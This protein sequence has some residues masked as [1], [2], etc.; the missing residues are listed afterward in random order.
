MVD[1]MDELRTTEQR[2]PKHAIDRDLTSEEKK[3]FKAKRIRANQLAQS[4]AKK[5]LAEKGIGAGSRGR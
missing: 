1:F 3:Q 4:K 2:N 5:N